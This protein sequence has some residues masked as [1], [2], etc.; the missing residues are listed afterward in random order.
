MKINFILPFKRMTGGI[1]VA[2]IYA[3]YLV[4]QGHDVVC[5]V[6]M[7]SYKGKDQSF[8]YRL[9]ASLGNTL[10]RDDWFDKKFKLKLVPIIANR[11]IRDADVTIATAW[12]TAYDVNNFSDSKGKKVY[13][14]QDIEIFNGDTQLVE[15]SYKLPLEIITVTENL[16]STLNHY[17]NNVTVVYNGLFDE[18]YMHEEKQVFDPPSLMMMYHESEHKCSQQGLKIIDKLKETYPDIKVNIFGRRI[19]EKLPEAYNV[20]VNPPRQEIIN[21]YRESDIYLFTSE[22][23]SWGLPIVEAMANK[24]AVVGRERGALAE[25]YNGDNAVLIDELDGMYNAVLDLISDKE[26]LKNMQNSAYQTVQKLNW[27]KSCKEFGRIIIG[28]INV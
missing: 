22:I 17:S 9:K 11:F 3:N 20:K 10:K 5:Y 19:P 6:P 24:C 15:N 1:R 25:L 16:K 21:M 12:Q 8:L 27:E 28:D 4:D 2:Y 18:E 23:E 7:L 14:V 13:L 26:K